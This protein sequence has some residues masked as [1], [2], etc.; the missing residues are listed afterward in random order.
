[1]KTGATWHE[2]RES[3]PRRWGD[4]VP[5]AHPWL[6]ATMSETRLE[7]HCTI[8]RDVEIIEIHRGGHLPVKAAINPATSLGAPYERKHGQSRVQHRMS[9]TAT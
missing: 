2:E 3:H 9:T 6:T 1:M 8:S 4:M 7:I 5:D